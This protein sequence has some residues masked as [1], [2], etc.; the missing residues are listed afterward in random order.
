M[1]AI[2]LSLG[3]PN[4][5]FW[6]LTL[7]EVRAVIERGVELEKKATLRAALIAAQIVNV[8][9]PKGARLVQPQDFIREPPSEDDY[10]TVDESRAALNAWAAAINADFAQ[11]QEPEPLVVDPPEETR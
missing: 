4:E 5:L 2:A 6:N 11:L 9:R 7:R 3:V 8:N 1:W 10:M